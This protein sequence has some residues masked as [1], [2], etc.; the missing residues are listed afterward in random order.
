V[1]AKATKR[2]IVTVTRVAINNKGNG[3][4]DEG[5]RQATAMRAMAAV[6]TVVAK[7]EGGDNSNK[8]GG[9]QRG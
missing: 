2:A 9:Q 6:T 8:G 1:K 3:N 5:S 4:G 7:D